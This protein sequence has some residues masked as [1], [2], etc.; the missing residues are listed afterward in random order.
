MIYTVTFNPALDYVVRVD[1]FTLGAV[2]RTEQESIYYG[3]K[4][5]NVSAVLSTLGY[6]NTALGFVAGFTGEEIERGVKGLGFQ[7]DFIR[8]EKGLSRINVKLKSQEETEINGM[9]PEITGNDVKQLFEKLDRLTAGDVLVLSG[10]IPKSIDDDIY[11]RI[12]KSLDGRGVRMVVD[13]T[14]DLLI[15]VLSY[16]PFL[17]KPNNH[18]LGEMFGVTLHGPEEIISYGK[19]LQEKGAR[20]VLISMAGDGAILITE[21]GEVFRMGVPK[22]TVKNSVGAG[23]S[24]VAGFIA[25]YLENGS[26]KHALRLGSAA[27]SA[28]AFS[29]GLAGKEDI[30]RLYE[31]LSKE[32]F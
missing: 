13:A 20:N 11:E 23:D 25:G 4:G 2:N 18:E 5:L 9:G 32:G 1:H 24:M 27:G 8:V 31:E 14:K 16:Q 28:S 29:E 21:E 12:M 7:S 17:I 10:S 22:G 6:G 30:M 15:N 3:G 19:R 26:Y